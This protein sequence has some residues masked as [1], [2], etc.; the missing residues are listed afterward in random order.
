MYQDDSFKSIN[1]KVYKLLV[2]QNDDNREI[3]ETTDMSE[4]VDK[5]LNNLI[6]LDG[7]LL[8]YTNR[9]VG[10]DVNVQA[11]GLTT[12]FSNAIGK[13]V[14]VMKQLENQMLSLDINNVSKSSI[15]SLTEYRD[16]Y[17]EILNSI[18]ITTDDIK[19]QYG[20]N[21]QVPLEYDQVISTLSSLINNINVKLLNYN[22]TVGDPVSG[23]GSSY[24]FSLFNTSDYQ[25]TQFLRV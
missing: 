18:Q 4:E 9:L 23:S 3:A 11:T 22:Q 14:T 1:E 5:I 2:N 20:P 12:P 19:D 10:E 15:E 16:K 25:P 7:F 24:S 21:D 13:M 17:T 8:D 6:E